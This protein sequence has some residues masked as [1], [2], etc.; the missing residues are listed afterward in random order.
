MGYL[1]PALSTAGGRKAYAMITLKDVYDFRFFCEEDSRIK[2]TVQVPQTNSEECK[3]F[4][5]WVSG[6]VALWLFATWVD[7]DGVV[8][9]DELVGIVVYYTLPPITS[10]GGGGFKLVLK[11]TIESL[12]WDVIFALKAAC[13]DAKGRE[14]KT[15]GMK[16]YT[17]EEMKELEEEYSRQQMDSERTENIYAV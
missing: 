2:L 6:N 12:T 14:E 8:S 4:I 3:K 17:A 7:S 1:I 16:L 15:F 10:G 13:K 5:S 11:S 9:E